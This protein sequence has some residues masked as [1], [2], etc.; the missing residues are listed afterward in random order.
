MNRHLHPVFQKI[1]EPL[2][3]KCSEC[4]LS[5]DVTEKDICLLCERA[6]DLH[7]EECGGSWTDGFIV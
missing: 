7:D 6:R 2:E 1:L 3:P 4:G 5:L